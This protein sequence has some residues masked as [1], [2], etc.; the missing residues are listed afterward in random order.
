MRDFQDSASEL[1][2]LR[3]RMTRGAAGADAQ[4]TERDLL[5]QIS[6]RRRTLAQAGSMPT[7]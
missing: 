7:D 1:A 5:G 2:L 4:D 6:A 3:E